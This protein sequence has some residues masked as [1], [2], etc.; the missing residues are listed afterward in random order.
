M[1]EEQRNTDTRE[2]SVNEIPMVEHKKK[3]SSETFTIKKE[4]LWKYT[5][6][7]LAGVLIV[8]GFFAFS[9]GGTPTGAAVGAPNAPSPTPTPTP[10]A[11]VEIEIQDG[12]H[13]KGDPDA[14]VKIFEFSDFEC[15]FCARFY[16]QTYGQI[17]SEYIENGDVAIIFKH[18]PLSIHANA[19]KA[20]EAAECAGDQGKFWEMHDMLFES[21]TT[22]GVATYK[23]YA[24]DLGLNTGD[25]DECLDTGQFADKVKA[26]FTQGTGVG[27]RGTPGFIINGKPVSGAQPF[28]VFQQAIDAEL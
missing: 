10:G 15:P 8:G 22:G 2:S 6:F 9:D 18:F 20:A 1:E 25:F 17:D 7:V 13:V 4:A 5:T 3:E 28:E 14:P 11:P 23:G 24:A 21:G 12:D 16:T 26:D 19:Q 27:I